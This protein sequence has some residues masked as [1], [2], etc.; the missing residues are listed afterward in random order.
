MLEVGFI[1]D[2]SCVEYEAK[3]CQKYKYAV[4]A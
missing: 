3:V 1:G 2:D 4:Y